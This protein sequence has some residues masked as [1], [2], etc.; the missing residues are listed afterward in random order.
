MRK[1]ISFEEAF[2]VFQKTLRKDKALYLAYKSN[3]A[4]SFYDVL[5]NE[6][7][8]LPGLQFL[9]NKAANNFLQLLIK[10]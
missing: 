4:M 2:K 7:Y 6:G 3:I 10:R 8:R 5:T 1:D 9:C